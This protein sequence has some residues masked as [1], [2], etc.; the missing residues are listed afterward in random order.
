[1]T[2]KRTK[3]EET[4]FTGKSATKTSGKPAGYV[5]GALVKQEPEAKLTRA[6]RIDLA[7]A[8]VTSGLERMAT[9]LSTDVPLPVLEACYFV[10]DKVWKKPIEQMR[11]LVNAALKD[12]MRAQETPLTELVLDY[13][14]ATYRAERKVQKHT[15]GNAPGME[16][17]KDLCARA[18]LKLS[19]VTH[20]V[21]SV[22]YDAG[23]VDALIKAGKLT[24]ALVEECRRVKQESLTIE[25]V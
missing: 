18:G 19:D 21:V 12:H 13:S 8:E 9:L 14:G 5:G 24:S 16:D 7:S 3:N 25:K 15:M 10:I 6:Q 22:E 17:V 20:E 1:M 2:T 4:T 23:K 11:N